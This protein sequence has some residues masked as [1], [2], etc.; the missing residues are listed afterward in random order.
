MSGLIGNLEPFIPG[1]NFTAYEDRLNQF[2][3]VNKVDEVFKT[4]LLITIIGADI[5]DV[6]ISLTV[7]ELP[8]AKPFTFLIEKLREHFAPKQNKRAERYKFNKAFQEEGESITEFMIR[9][10]SLSQT[11]QFADFM[12]KSVIKDSLTA[13]KTST[14]SSTGSST[15]TD[16]TTAS[17]STGSVSIVARI[18]NHILEDALTDRFIM[19]L[20][21]DKIQQMLLNDDSLTFADCCNKA[22]NVEMAEKASQSIQ[23]GGQFAVQP[24]QAG[25]ASKQNGQFHRQKNKYWKQSNNKNVNQS[26]SNSANKN[27]SNQKSSKDQACRRC[28]RSHDENQCPAKSWL[29][30]TCNKTGHTSKVCRNK[31]MNSV[32]SLE[33]VVESV[34]LNCEVEN[35]KM[36]FEV[37]T[38]ACATVMSREEYLNKFNALKLVKKVNNFVT[39]TGENIQE[40]GH[41]EVRVGFRG[42]QYKLHIVVIDSDRSFRA[43]MGR[44]W[45]DV[46]FRTWRSIFLN[47]PIDFFEQSKLATLNVEKLSSEINSKFEGYMADIV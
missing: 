38:G 25:S 27:Q 14:S 18:K 37:D 28:G 40:L 20:R 30:F 33:S 45:L 32:N 12:E 26:N 46:L 1:G 36:E 23:P 24:G 43:L 22:L 3:L 11:C 9:I 16:A 6:L 17:V 29:C 15:T 10:K 13:L 31:S 5:Y 21:S 19:G 44:N 4:P 41:I 8:S 35:R 42:L 47:F 39:V 2:F 34:I 7:P